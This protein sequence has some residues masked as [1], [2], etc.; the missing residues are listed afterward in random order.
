MFRRL[1]LCVAVAVVA[2]SPAL[3]QCDHGRLRSAATD[4]PRRLVVTNATGDRTA[5][6]VWVNHRGDRITYGTIAPGETWAQDTFVGHVWLL[7]TETGACEAQL[8]VMGNLR[9]IVE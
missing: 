7:E 6:L 5:S 4:S 2:A 9:L 3:A 1:V 8:R